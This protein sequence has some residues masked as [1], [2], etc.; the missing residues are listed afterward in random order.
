MIKWA[1]R[2]Y[3]HRRLGLVIIVLMT[4]FFAWQIPRLTIETQFRDLYPKAHAHT[5]LFEQYPQFGSPLSVILVVH[6]REGTIYNAATLTKIQEAT[7]LIDLLP[8]ID[9]NQIFS[10]ASS[11]NR[12]IEATTKGIRA[13]NFLVGPVPHDLTGLAKLRSQIHSA[14]D[15]LGILVSRHEDAALIQANFIE[16][17]ADYRAIFTGVNEII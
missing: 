6:V 2:L 8:G 5:K 9:H 4:L 11:K 12:H 1:E 10:I 14:P 7:K 16:R 15:V 13:S 17:L 3:H